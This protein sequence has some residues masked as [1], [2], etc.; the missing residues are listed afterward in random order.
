M[1]AML[2]KAPVEVSER[3]LTMTDPLTVA[4]ISQTCTFFRD[5]IYRPVYQHLWRTL[6]LA[7]YDD[8]RPTLTLLGKSKN[9]PWAS[10]LKRR[11][12]SETLMTR[13]EYLSLQDQ[14]FVLRTLTDVIWSFPSPLI[15]EHSRDLDW[16]ERLIAASNIMHASLD[17]DI[18]ELL[19]KLH[20]CHGLSSNEKK[21]FH[22]LQWP[23]RTAARHLVYDRHKYN[24]GNAWGPYLQNR[25]GKALIPPTGLNAVRPYSAPCVDNITKDWAGVEGHWYRYV[26]Y[27]DYRILDAFNFSTSTETEPLNYN[28]LYDKLFVE[29]IRVLAI[30]LRVTGSTACPSHPQ[31]PVIHFDGTYRKH[32]KD[33]GG[34]ILEGTV[35]MTPDDQIRWKYISTFDGVVR[36][37]SEGIQVG[38]VGS[39][40]GVLGAWSNDNHLETDPIGPF[41]IYKVV[42][43]QLVV[44]QTW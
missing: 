1:P 18:A 19:A 13:V 42:E 23:L 8:P 17:Q 28:V 21:C 33:T 30:Y 29:E 9:Y 20:V 37:L 39:A 7:S 14:K 11:F 5:L 25:P 10:E 36:W 26:C 35:S 6:F 38:G 40:M 12:R 3:I 41:W 27:L 31:R 22:S 32:G 24:K 2:L 16:L 15:L 4:F 43:H 44:H 34:R